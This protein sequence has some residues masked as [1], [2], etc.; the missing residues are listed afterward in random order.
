ML[1]ITQ[2]Y[3]VQFLVLLVDGFDNFEY[4]N[5]NEG[6][7]KWRDANVHDITQLV[8]AAAIGSISYL[9]VDRQGD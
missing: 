1:N 3:L 9:F 8:K 2:P 6:D 4:Y 5:Q 7:H